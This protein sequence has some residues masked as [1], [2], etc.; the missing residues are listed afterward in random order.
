MCITSS[1]D[2]ETLEKG[3]AMMRKLHPY[4]RGIRIIVC[5]V[6][7]LIWL[8]SGKTDLMLNVKPSIGVSSCAGKLIVEEAGGRVTNLRGES[9]GETDTLLIS[10]GLLH[11]QIV[12][13]ING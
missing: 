4:L 8:A 12:R 13:A 6:Y 10:N 2:E 5:T 9:R 11:E 7:E 3:L 1:Y